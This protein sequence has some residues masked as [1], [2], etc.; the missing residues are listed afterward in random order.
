LGIEQGSNFSC[1][2]LRFLSKIKY[3]LNSTGAKVVDLNKWYREM[4]SGQKKFVYFVSI[5]L[6]PIFL[7]G[8]L[9]LIV[10]IYLHLGQD[11]NDKGY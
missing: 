11:S 8:V 3:F 7:I 9:P 10:L 2:L 6:V 1:A 4:T 5:C